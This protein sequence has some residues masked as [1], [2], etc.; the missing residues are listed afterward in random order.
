MVEDYSCGM[1]GVNS[2]IVPVRQD[3][4]LLIQPT[5][6]DPVLAA[7]N[8][9]PLGDTISTRLPFRTTT[10]SPIVDFDVA[11]E[12]LR[13]GGNLGVAWTEANS[14]WFGELFFDPGAQTANLRA[15][16]NLPVTGGRVRAA[17]NPMRQ[18]WAVVATSL[19]GAELLILERN[20]NFP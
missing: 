2:R 8:C 18:Q 20:P 3:W 7:V 5:P 19:T 14:V 6:N 4:A 9:V 12:T 16:M 15:P 10:A 11:K 17:Y 1:S 13:I